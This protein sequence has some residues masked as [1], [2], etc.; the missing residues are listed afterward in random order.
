M[1]NCCVETKT[2]RENALLSSSTDDLLTDDSEDD[3]EE[4]F[5]CEAEA[6]EFMAAG[7]VPHRRRPKHSLWNKPVGR[8][9]RCENLRL[10]QTGEYLYIP[11]TQ[12]PTPKTEDQL[13]EDE[14]V[15]LQLGTDAQGMELRT[16]MMSASLLSDMESFK[17]ANPGAELEDFIRWYSPRDWVEEEEVD[18]FNQ[19]KGHLSPRMQLPGNMWVEVWTAAKPVPA[20]RQKRLFDDTREA[21]KVLHYLEAKQPREVALMLVSTLTHASVATLAHHAAPI[22]VPGLEPAVRHIAGKAELLSRA[23]ITDMRRYE[24]LAME[25]AW[26]ECV[27]AQVASLEHKL[28]PGAGQTQEMRK[29]L[30]ALVTQPEALVPGGP[31]GDIASRI[32]AMFS[33]AHKASQMISDNDP[34]SHITTEPWSPISSSVFPPA[35]EREFILRVLA[36]R[37]APTSL[38]TPH[39]L[40]VR[41]RKDEIIM[42]GCFSQDTTFQ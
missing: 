7:D 31:R 33:E 35:S 26:A 16:R 25:L 22:E 2:K 13:E 4:F 10:L 38:I 8:Y 27:V 28:C 41:L 40:S 18:E 14:R 23:P 19:K 34:S 17:A 37:P 42:A 5:D 1:L 24:E 30:A 36:P 12:D 11:V 3:E 20:R 9:K 21:E 15:M 6:E 29:F 39:R 32:R